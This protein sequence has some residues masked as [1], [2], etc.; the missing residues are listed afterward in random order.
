MS[1]K[2]RISGREGCHDKQTK[3]KGEFSGRKT[4]TIKEGGSVQE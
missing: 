3:N 4:A 1:K 2:G